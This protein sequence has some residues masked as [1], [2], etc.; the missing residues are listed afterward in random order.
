MCLA[1]G[2]RAVAREK[3][4]IAASTDSPRLD[5]S[6]LEV[7]SARTHTL[8]HSMHIAL[9]SHKHVF[10]L[11]IATCAGGCA[12]TLLSPASSSWRPSG[13]GLYGRAC[14]M[15]GCLAFAFE[16]ASTVLM[17]NAR[18]LVVG[19]GGQCSGVIRVAPVSAEAAKCGR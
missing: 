8:P 7:H 19:M 14:L 10:T 17:A 12:K 9:P 6:R 1:G 18:M 16:C 5:L 3:A 2:V 4:V 11:H 13:I 15:S